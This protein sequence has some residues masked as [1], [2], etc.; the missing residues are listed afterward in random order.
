MKFSGKGKHLRLSGGAGRVQ[1]RR[2]ARAAGMGRAGAARCLLL[3]AVTA[4]SSWRCPKSV[5]SARSEGVDRAL[6]AG[7]IAMFEVIA[8]SAR[9]QR[10]DHRRLPVRPQRQ[11]SQRR[12][13][14]HRRVEH[15]RLRRRRGAQGCST[16]STAGQRSAE[17]RPLPTFRV[18]NTRQGVS[19]IQRQAALYRRLRSSR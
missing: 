8:P 1:P 11:I 2:R 12:P 16:T 3:F 9:V 19:R 6:L 18:S 15:I 7:T 17:R 13:R 5:A 4:Q 10:R 14:N